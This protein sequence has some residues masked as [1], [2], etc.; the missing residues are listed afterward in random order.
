[1]VLYQH[2]STYFVSFSLSSLQF[3]K[4]EYLLKSDLVVSLL[5][6]LILQNGRTKAA[7]F[8]QLL[9]ASVIPNTVNEIRDDCIWN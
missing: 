8:F 1:M 9:R 2:G 5:G 3:Y 4:V 7:F 6:I